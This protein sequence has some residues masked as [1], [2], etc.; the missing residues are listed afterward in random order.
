[1][2]DLVQSRQTLVPAE[3]DE[4][5]WLGSLYCVVCLTSKSAL[6]FQVN[7]CGH[8]MCFYCQQEYHSCAEGMACPL[9][10]AEINTRFE[11]FSL[12]QTQPVDLLKQQ[13]A[14]EAEPVP[15]MISAAL[16]DSSV[17]DK[18]IQQYEFVEESKEDDG[19]SESIASPRDS[20]VQEQGQQQQ[21]AEPVEASI[22]LQQHCGQDPVGSESVLTS[23]QRML[24][25]LEKNLAS[26]LQ[27]NGMESDHYMNQSD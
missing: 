7:A 21:I 5:F 10:K 1:M 16:G 22:I 23:G 13:K 25:S 6:S 14:Q 18:S 8:A 17:L 24:N 2:P 26:R 11:C 9:C 4:D 3:P 15:A 19:P 27:L 20:L 12:E